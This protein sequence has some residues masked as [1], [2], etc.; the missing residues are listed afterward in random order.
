M[1]NGCETSIY[2]NGRF[3]TENGYKIILF[4]I[5]YLVLERGESYLIENH[6]DFEK[7]EK[8]I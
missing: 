1:V 6:S 5:Y 8:T 3:R 4:L 7:K 2:Y